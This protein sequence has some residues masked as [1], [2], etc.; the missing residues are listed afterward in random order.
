MTLRLK[1]FDGDYLQQVP[2]AV[3]RGA[4]LLGRRVDEPG[5]RVPPHGS[6][7]GQFPDPSVGRSRVRGIGQADGDPSHQLVQRPRRPLGH[8][9]ILTLLLLHCQCLGRVELS[10]VPRQMIGDPSAANAIVVQHF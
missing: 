3:D 10:L 7:V 6:A 4:S 2:W 5:G 1:A 8:V 9:S